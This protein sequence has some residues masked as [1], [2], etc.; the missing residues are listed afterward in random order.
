M[1]TMSLANKTLPALVFAGLIMNAASPTHAE[2]VGMRVINEAGRIPIELSDGSVYGLNV[3]AEV[4]EVFY[5]PIKHELKGEGY[6]L[7][8]QRVRS[9]AGRPLK[10]CG[11]GKEVRLHVYQVVA[12]QLNERANV[13]VSSCLRSV[14]L[15]SQNTGNENQETDFSSVH[16]NAEGFSIDW[17]NQVDG[18]GR[19]ISATHYG[20]QGD[21]FVPQEVVSVQGEGQ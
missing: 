17:F 15:L 9:L 20:L 6:V 5:E 13:L 10:R 19:Q 7:L 8:F 14:S 21:T 11:A 3:P 4:E 12:D 2:S 16:W 1:Q 18:A